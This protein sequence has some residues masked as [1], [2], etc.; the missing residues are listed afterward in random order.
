MHIDSDNMVW[1]ALSNK[2]CLLCAKMC[3]IDSIKFK[4][5]K[6]IFVRLAQYPSIQ[7]HEHRLGKFKFPYVLD[8]SPAFLS[9]S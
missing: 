5:L 3:I 2:V 1:F 6:T 9:H 4:L 8:A 7:E